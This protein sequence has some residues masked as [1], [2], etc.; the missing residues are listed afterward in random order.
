MAL[1]I[2]NQSAVFII[3]KALPNILL[4]KSG[5]VAL[6]RLKNQKMRKTNLFLEVRRG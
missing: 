5:T 6:L 4:R 3:H 2:Y 1:F